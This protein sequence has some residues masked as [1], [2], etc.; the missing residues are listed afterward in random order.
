MKILIISHEYPPVGGGGA[1][2]CMNLA[3]EYSGQGHE[4][5]IVTVWFAGEKEYEEI[6]NIRIYRVRSKRQ[7]LEHCS[8]TEMLDYLKK[9][10]PLAD[11]LE[12]KERY[13]ICQVFFGIPSGPVGYVLKKKYHLPYV[14]RFG[15]GDIPGFQDRFTSVYKLIGPCIKAIWKNAD[16]LVANSQGLKKMA[17]DFYD[18][19]NI[20]II[21][22]GANVR[23][24]STDAGDSDLQHDQNDIRL[25]FVSRLIERKGLQDILP[26]MKELAD[27]CYSTGKTIHFDI[28]GDGP[29]REVLED[30]VSR[31][32]I[33]D[34]VTFHGQ[35]SKAE[36]PAYYSAAD[37]FIFPSRKEGMPNVVLEAMSYGLPVIMTPCQGSDELIDGNGYVIDAESFAGRI[38]EL[39]ED[40]G[41]RRSMGDRSLELVSEVFSWRQTANKYMELFG[42]ITHM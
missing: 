17:M 30:I 40:I 7:K 6:D 23:A 9:A 10:M 18:K 24:F 36:L 27:R 33:T 35:K 15:G 14:I 25:L 16:A 1:N 26:Q 21:P 3:R 37:I 4:V 11:R 41:K 39:T 8:F 38:Y 5:S 34:I 2:A 22:N 13:D 20:M 19:K 42:A 29:Y 12:K 31:Y 32:G 28:V